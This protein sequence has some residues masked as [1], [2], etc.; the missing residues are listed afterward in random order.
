M[1]FEILMFSTIIMLKFFLRDKINCRCRRCELITVKL[2][3]ADYGQNEKKC[4]DFK[5]FA[6]ILKKNIKKLT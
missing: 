3:R 6:Q 4:R 5:M 2:I 1:D